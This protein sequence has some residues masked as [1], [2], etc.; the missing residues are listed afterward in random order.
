MIVVTFP[1]YI[2]TAV[3]CH[4]IEPS[5]HLGVASLHIEPPDSRSIPLSI[6]LLH[7]IS[8][9]PYVQLQRREQSPARI[10][11]EIS[12]IYLRTARGLFFPSL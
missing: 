12:F 7:C 9:F 11:L 1:L 5:K 6:D 3:G 4:D 8:Y 10:Q 2:Y